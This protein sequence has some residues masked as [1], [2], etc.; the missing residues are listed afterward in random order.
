MLLGEP[1]VDCAA[2]LDATT[3]RPGLAAVGKSNDHPEFVIGTGEVLAVLTGPVT[4]LVDTGIVNPVV[5]IPKATRL[6]FLVVSVPPAVACL[7]VI[8]CGPGRRSLEIPYNPTAPISDPPLI[9]REM[10]VP[11]VTPSTRTSHRPMLDVEDV[12]LRATATKSGPDVVVVI[13]VANPSTGSKAMVVVVSPVASSVS[14]AEGRT[15]PPAVVKGNATKF[16]F[17]VK[18]VPKLVR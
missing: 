10:V 6:A 1:S 12:Q 3:I 9:Y 14:L 4:A 11:I 8:L 17:F 7:T 2:Q 5:F 16:T 15:E 13:V 18:S